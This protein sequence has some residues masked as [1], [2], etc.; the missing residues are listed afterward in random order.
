MRIAVIGSS[1]VAAIKAAAP[2]IADTY[3]DVELTFFALPGGVF[4]R[5]T[6]RDG[7]ISAASL[8]AVET[9]LVTK[10]N[11]NTAL[12]V[13]GYDHLWVV[14]DRFGFGQVLQLYSR[15]DPPDGRI[16]QIVEN[17]VAR[18]FSQFGFDDRLTFSPAPY[19]AL[20]AKVPGPK[21]ELRLARIL[22]HP[23]GAAVLARFEKAISIALTAKGYGAVLQPAAT[24]ALIFTTDDRFLYKAATL[25]AGP[26]SGSD[27][28]HMNAAY[29]RLLF[30]AF[31]AQRLA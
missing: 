26:Q 31:A 21:Q 1:H 22:H 24:R 13:D 7:I 20:Q 29:G 6:L 23:D 5:A 8:D 30:D 3:P 15:H 16:D 11:G 19:P 28:R 10:I 27:L 18:L 17:H 2:E 4:R 9:A 14:G 25:A 12:H